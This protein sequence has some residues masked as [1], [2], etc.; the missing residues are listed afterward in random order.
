[1]YVPCMKALHPCSHAEE[2]V[3]M[4]D[5][6]WVR[7]V[8][9]CGLRVGDSGAVPGVSLCRFGDHMSMLKVE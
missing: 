7:T 8:L 4:V 1:M 5:R 9:R 2:T 3:W 6:Q